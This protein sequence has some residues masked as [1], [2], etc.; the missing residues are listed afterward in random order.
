MSD[1]ETDAQ[2]ALIRKNRAI[3]QRLNSF[4]H[5]VLGRSGITL[6]VLLMDGPMRMSD[7]AKEMG[8]SPAALTGL[9]DRLEKLGW[10][11]RT[12]HRDRRAY[13]MVL[14]D[15]AFEILAE[16]FGQNHDGT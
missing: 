8:L 16:A 15:N 9:R 11:E 2:E 10:T 7:I 6:A 3:W 13:Y 14:T 5:P 1:E 12:K 4:I